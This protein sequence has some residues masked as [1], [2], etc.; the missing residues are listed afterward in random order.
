MARPGPQDPLILMNEA[1]LAL[2]VEVAVDLVGPVAGARLV[3]AGPSRLRLTLARL[4]LPEATMICAD[5]GQSASRKALGA[6]VRAMG[7]IDGL[8]LAGEG[9]DSAQMFAI[10]QT[11]VTFLPGLRHGGGRGIVLVVTDGPALGS[12]RQFLRRLRPSCD[13]RGIGLVLHVP[14]PSAACGG[15]G[16]ADR[17]FA[18]H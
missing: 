7:R 2:P 8:V 11:I 4:A 13:R 5:F 9:A 6:R 15:A 16:S 14:D 3:V 17:K 18:T 12:L 10:M 1:A